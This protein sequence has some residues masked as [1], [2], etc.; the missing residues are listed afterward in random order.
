[1]KRILRPGHNCSSLERVTGAGLLIDGEDYY[2]AF[3]QA[4]GSARKTIMIAGWQFD[5]DVRLLR[6]REERRAG[7]DVRLLPFL[8]SLCERNREL[9]VYILAWDFSIFF[10]LDHQWVQRWLFNWS[11]NDRLHFQFDSVHAI[12]ASHH[13]KLVVI[14]GVLAFAGGLDICSR[15]WDGRDHA[16]VNMER[17]D[18]NGAPYE[19]YHDVQAYITGPPAQGLSEY[20]RNRWLFA[21]GRDFG[22]RPPAEGV[23]FDIGHAVP[24]AAGEVAISYT[25]ARLP[26]PP[27]ERI[28]EIKFLYADALSAAEEIIYIENQFFSS[29]WVYSSL[30]KR[31]NA[32]EMPR[33]QV[34]IVLPK[35]FNAF[36]E[37]MTLAVAQVSILRSLVGAAARNGHSLGIYYAS[38]HDEE[39]SEVQTYIHSKVLIIDDRFLS[40]GSAN[41]SNRSMSLDTELNLSWEAWS[42]GHIELADSIRRIRADLLAEHT[43]LT[44]R[45]HRRRL[46]KTEGLVDYL[47]G[48]SDLARCRLHR[49]RMETIFEDYKW[50]KS[51]TPENFGFDPE[52][53]LI[54]E[55]W[56]ESVLSDDEAGFSTSIK[57][58]IAGLGPAK[59]RPGKIAR[60][61][62]AAI[63]TKDRILREVRKSRRRKYFLYFLLYSALFS[64]LWA[65]IKSC[66]P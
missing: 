60:A 7:R 35:R 58:L 46:E 18:G 5:S 29:R 25:Q 19:P 65:L 66:Y 12:G 63:V 45:A 32:P 61:E 62:R 36:L 2:R 11:T 54:G 14:D 24:I 23:S 4:A 50:L 64:L 22:H 42:P 21:G 37:E 15:H 55:E 8:D 57:R 51:I 31:L 44:E 16:A 3:Y 40:V 39:G 52:E 30:L 34:V 48:L 28:Q 43:G 49:H 20:F 17:W 10:S 47:E 38:S 53:P 33:L 1:M 59:P 41:L 6:G 27:L 26:S 9:E 56:Y 13:L